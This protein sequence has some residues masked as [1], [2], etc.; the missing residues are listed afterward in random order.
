[1]SIPRPVPRERIK[2]ILSELQLD[3]LHVQIPYHPW[4]AG[5]VIREASNTTAVVGTFHIL[6][7][8]SLSAFGTRA[9]ATIQKQ[10]HQRFDVVTSTSP[11]ARNFAKS[12]YKLDSIVLPNA[13]DL[14]TFKPTGPKPAHKTQTIVFLGRLVRRKGAQYLLAA[15]NELHHTGKLANVKVI[16]GG[17][18]ELA[19]DLYEYT[20]KHK[21]E[22]IVEFRGFIPESDKASLLPQA[23]IAVFPAVSGESFGIV[24]LE[25][26][27]SG[28]GVTRGG[29][30]PGY[31]S[32]LQSI[33]ESI[34]DPTHTHKFA[35]ALDAFLH[36]QALA[37]SVHTK[38]MK[39][40]RQF[41][42]NVIGQRL[43]TLYRET[44]L[45]RR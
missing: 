17:K 29:A 45:K 41:D 35:E 38:Q 15:I 25:A 11:A 24:L 31:K 27:A 7:A 14:Q 33:P 42:I 37:N 28:A 19:K 44:L 39:L 36:D 23:D 40:V 9:L 4:L 2:H 32:V 3:V 16:I 5:R 22:S 43:E 21:L 13:I 6:P 30:N 1:M 26:M 18:G 12:H 10:T 34:V 8:S 20:R